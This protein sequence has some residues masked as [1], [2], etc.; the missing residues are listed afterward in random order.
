MIVCLNWQRFVA[1]IESLPDAVTH[2]MHIIFAASVLE[3]NC[4]A[5][6]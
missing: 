6:I 1:G 2:C 3:S 5:V 4:L